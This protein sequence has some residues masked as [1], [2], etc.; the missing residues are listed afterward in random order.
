MFSI[1]EAADDNKWKEW[2]AGGKNCDREFSGFDEK[3]INISK[4]ISKTT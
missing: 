4:Q 2:E 1:L 3:L